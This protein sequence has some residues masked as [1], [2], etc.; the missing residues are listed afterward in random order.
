MGLLEKNNQGKKSL[1][2]ERKISGCREVGYAST[3][4]LL[5]GNLGVEGESEIG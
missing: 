5:L 3:G 1:K 4:E 2:E